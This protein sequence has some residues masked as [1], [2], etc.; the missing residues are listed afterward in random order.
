MK[1]FADDFNAFWFAQ[2]VARGGSQDEAKVEPQPLLLIGAGLARTGTASF[3]KAMTML[4]LN[5]YH[6]LV[7]H[8]TRGHLDMWRRYLLDGDN[9][10]DVVVT[11]EDIVQELAALGVNATVDAPTNFDYQKL[12]QLYPQAKVILTI[13][14]EENATV[15]A[16]KWADSMT[17]SVLRVLPIASDIPWRWFPVARRLAEFDVALYKHAK[18]PQHKQDRH[19]LADYYREWNEQVVRNVPADNL[20]VFR[21]TDGWDPLCDC[22]SSVSDIIRTNCDALIASDEPYP[23]VHDSAKLKSVI[24]VFVVISILFKAMLVVVPIVA[25]ARLLIRIRS[26]ANDSKD[27]SE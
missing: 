7:A 13:R 22:L 3:Q 10:G 2:N 17:S 21:A 18:L 23:H 14:S 6:M 26:K 4:G 20:L 5:C 11:L 1:G 27:K 15:A 9:D 8:G 19:L 25:S 24:A 16:E 12:M